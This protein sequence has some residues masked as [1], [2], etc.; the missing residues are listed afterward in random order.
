ML[1]A[2]GEQRGTGARERLLEG[3]REK[4]RQKSRAFGTRSPEY[5]RLAIIKNSKKET[6]GDTERAGT[7]EADAPR[8]ERDG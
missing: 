5:W 7:G 1:A 4:E 2:R 3:K 6:R 8:R